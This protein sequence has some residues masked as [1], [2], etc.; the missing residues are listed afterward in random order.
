MRLQLKA[1][2]D[3]IMQQGIYKG[4]VL[5]DVIDKDYGYIE[6]LKEL[7]KLKLHSESLEYLINKRHEKISELS[8]FCDIARG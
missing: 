5:K 1:K 8:K 2:L 7:G 4:K 3:H 6:K